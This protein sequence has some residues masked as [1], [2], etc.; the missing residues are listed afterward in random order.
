MAKRGTRRAGER[1]KEL[2]G[3]IVMAAG[4]GK[5][6]Q[7]KLAK[8]LH[9]VAGRP[10]VLYAV[11]LARRVA[12][13]YV[14][15]VV[16]HQGNEVRAAIE[17]ERPHESVV[18]VE[19]AQPLGTGHAVQRAR[20]VLRQMGW[21]CSAYLILNADTPLLQVGTVQE[22]VRLHWEERATISLLTTIMENPDGYGRVIRGANGRVRRIVEDRDA[23]ATERRV[24][25]VNVGTYV[26]DGPFLV[27]AVDKLRPRNAQ[28]ECYL[29]DL[30]ALAAERGL[31]VSALT[32]QDA[33]EAIGIN[34]R[35]QLAAAE[36]V[37]RRRICGHWMAQGVTIRDP[38]STVIDAS[39]VIGRDTILYPGVMLEG[40][41]TIGEGCVIRSHTRISDSELGN[42]VLVQDHCV[43]QDA[44]V[45]D[46]AVVGPFAHLRPGSV[47]RRAA[48][49]GNFVE[50]KQTELG[51][52]SKAN[53]LTYLGDAKIGKGVNVGAGT[54]TCN[55]DGYRKHGTVIEDDVF[56]GSDTQLIAP[57]T[58]GRGAVIA[59][60]TTVTG[61]VPP[62]A[63]AIARVPQVNRPGWAIRRRALLAQGGGG[64]ERSVQKDGARNAQSNRL[65][66]DQNRKPPML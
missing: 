57:V 56:V 30:V 55:Y 38:A 42:R 58:I 11:E 24:R 17:A 60:G 39:V 27:E 34:T 21:S 46:E 23:S 26:V 22:L 50:L 4:L 59:A 45:E 12:G 61:D 13:E 33:S 15:V 52:G 37:F 6:M 5:R 31:T 49:V 19:Q 65:A 41:T 2:L 35:E 32:V 18:I 1:P 20:D 36:Q 14:A 51:E 54:I 3:A 25:E 53:H 48:K 63:L 10:M 7:S 43:I 9:P 64:E 47:L 66:E 8:V 62:D 44:R 16:G 40:R 28:A 29:T